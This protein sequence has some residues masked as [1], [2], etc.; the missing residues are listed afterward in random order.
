[1]TEKIEK[2]TPAERMNALRAT[3]A[4][5]RAI[6]RAQADAAK[7]VNAGRGK[8]PGDLALLWLELQPLT[9]LTGVDERILPLLRVAA[10]GS[11]RA[12]TMAMKTLISVGWDVG[13]HSGHPLA[14][15]EAHDH[16]GRSYL[17]RL[18]G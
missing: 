7:S 4:A 5:T 2:L 3:N 10:C 13:A 12:A 9:P 18:V 15:H 8:T 6:A 14:T 1:M 11:V 17:I 16:A